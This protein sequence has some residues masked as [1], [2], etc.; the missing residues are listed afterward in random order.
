MKLNKPTLVVFDLDDTLYAY[1]TSNEKAHKALVIAGAAETGLSEPQ[2]EAVLTES[3]LLVKKRLGKTG[4]SHSRLLY[5]HEALNQLGFANQPALSLALEQ[6]FW[7]EYLLSMKL[8]EG[9]EE[10]L[11]SL[12]F[13][14]IPIALVTDLTLQIQLRKLNF[15]KLDAFFDA[16][17]ASEETSG[18][19]PTLEPFITLAQRVDPAWL[20][21]VWFVGDH[22]FDG[23]VAELKETGL[24]KDGVSWIMKPNH[25]KSATGWNRLE[26]IEDALN[27]ALDD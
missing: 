2:F 18:D 11:L 25:D 7:R 9:A 21:N 27:A 4:A 23:P 13:N 14:H 3:R 26:E 1:K 15:L 5:I 19:K 22:G 8:R 12:R 10:L 17:V 6:T 20:D 24:I 16:I